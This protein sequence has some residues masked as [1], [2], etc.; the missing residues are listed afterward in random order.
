MVPYKDISSDSQIIIRFFDKNT[1]SKDLLWHRDKE[2]RII[3][4]LNKT[5]W[6]IQLDNQLPILI[7]K[8]IFIPKEVWHR[9]IKGSDSIT[10]KILKI[11]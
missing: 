6:K 8:P 11:K 5:D 2:D 7:D 9:I 1:E 10:L 3:E 4:S